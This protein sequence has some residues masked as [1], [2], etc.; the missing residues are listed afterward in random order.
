M[1]GVG[2]ELGSGWGTCQG[3]RKL[4][5]GLGSFN[6]LPPPCFGSKQVCL[7]SS[8]VESRFLWPRRQSYCFLNRLRGLVFPVSDPRAGVPNR[9]FTL[10]TPQEVSPH[11]WNSPLLCVPSQGCRSQP[12][13]VSSLPTQFHVDFSY[14]LVC[15]RVF[16]PVSSLFSV[17]IALY[18][19]IFLMC[20]WEEV[21]SVSSYSIFIP[22]LC[23]SILNVSFAG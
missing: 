1:R 23:P 16:L 13:H 7:C 9:W 12:D 17:R 21:S 6:L 10:L 5:R 4:V 8:Q 22:L 14:S 3:C 11:P 19:E 15:M 20:S 2:G 18:V